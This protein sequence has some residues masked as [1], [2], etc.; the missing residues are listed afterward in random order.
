MRNIITTYILLFLLIVNPFAYGA[1]IGGNE[2]RIGDETGSDIEILMGSGRLKWDNGASEMQFSTDGGS[3]YVAIG[4]GGGGG[5]TG[6]INTITNGDFEDP[7]DAVVGWTATTPS[8]FVGETG[9]SIFAFGSTSAAF[10]S[11]AAETVTSDAV[12]VPNG[13]KNGF[14]DL[15]FYYRGDATGQTVGV[16]DGSAYVASLDDLIDTGTDYE[17]AQLTFTCPSSGTFAVRVETSS[18]QPVVYYDNFELGQSSSIR[19]S[20]TGGSSSGYVGG[21]R[22]SDNAGACNW[23]VSSYTADVFHELVDDPDCIT[24]RELFGD[25]LANTGKYQAD[26]TSLEAGTYQVSANLSFAQGSGSG[27]NYACRLVDSNDYVIAHAFDRTDSATDAGNLFISGIV[28]Y[29]SAQGATSFRV[30]CA[31]SANPTN[32]KGISI[33]DNFTIGVSG[34]STASMPN[35]HVVKLEGTATAATKQTVVDLAP[36]LTDWYIDAKWHADGNNVSLGTATVASAT[37]MGHASGQLVLDSGSQPVEVPCSGGNTS[38]GLTCS[39]GDERIGIV[40]DAPWQGAYEIC[41]DFSHNVNIQSGSTA[42]R[43]GFRINE[44]PNNAETLT[45]EGD[46]S[47]AQ[48]ADSFYVGGGANFRHMHLC[49]TFDLSQGQHTFRLMYKQEIT[50]SVNESSMFTNNTAAYY[51][52]GVN[53]KVRPV[54]RTKVAVQLDGLVTQADIDASTIRTATLALTGGGC[55]I[56]AQDSPAW[57]SSVSR[58]ST[59]QCSINFSSAYAST[60]DFSCFCYVL[61]NDRICS[62]GT[63]LTTSMTVEINN[64]GGSAA[65]HN[66]EL[67]CK[68]R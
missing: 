13:L 20:I 55:T 66:F 39:S 38:T 10:N 28:E 21:F 57:I 3:N 53:F 52:P 61:Q 41:A 49:E 25:A 7:V 4:S 64:P 60:D 6:G 62:G 31:N 26:F 46:N 15:T 36:D 68:E 29:G 9:A 34:G 48:I 54:S 58:P 17:K 59:G 40:F 23:F 67:A 16:W 2:L 51:N 44:T 43:V 63:K 35:L 45:V 33:V 18:D 32:D 30:E 47:T 37:A 1:Q 65:D 5:G 50:G 14:C 8:N 42:I 12:T 19:T 22:Q 56:T 24:Y 11:T 27:S